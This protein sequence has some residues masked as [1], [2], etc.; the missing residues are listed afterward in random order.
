MGVWI[1][2]NENLPEYDLPVLVA[3]KTQDR[4][5]SWIKEK[6]YH[7]VTAIDVLDENGW[8]E[9]RNDVVAWMYLP[10]P[11]K[12]DEANQITMEVNQ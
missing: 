8:Y 10:E 4:R 2:V 5:P 6:T 11:Y 7:Y 12:G 3:V 1:S 9:F